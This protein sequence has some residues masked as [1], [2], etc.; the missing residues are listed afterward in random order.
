MDIKKLFQKK[1]KLE[2]AKKQ[3]T[4]DEMYQ[5]IMK[6]REEEIKKTEREIEE[7]IAYKQGGLQALDNG[8]GARSLNSA[9]S[10]FAKEN[11]LFD[12]LPDVKNVSNT[13]IKSSISTTPSEYYTKQK[14][15]GYIRQNKYTYILEQLIKYR[16]IKE[17]KSN[18]QGILLSDDYET[19]LAQYNFE[20]LSQ[21]NKESCDCIFVPYLEELKKNGLEYREYELPNRIWNLHKLTSTDIHSKYV[22]RGFNE[23]FRKDVICTGITLLDKLGICK[24]EESK[25]FKELSPE[26]QKECLELSKKINFERATTLPPEYESY[27]TEETL[28]KTR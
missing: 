22:D 14:R 25:Y 15:T 10:N 5:Q 20:R 6:K 3:P 24:L 18:F 13:S 27:V 28:G 4:A 12:E 1:K 16:K 2:E 19:V 17:L 9:I 11:P 7:S 21:T 23:S 8:P 26:Y